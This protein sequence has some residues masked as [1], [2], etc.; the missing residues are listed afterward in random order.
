MMNADQAEP[1]KRSLTGMDRI[2]RMNS[3]DKATLLYGF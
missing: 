3:R 1:Q 2:T